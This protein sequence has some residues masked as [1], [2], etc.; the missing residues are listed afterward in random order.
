MVGKRFIEVQ[1]PGA[2]LIG[3]EVGPVGRAG[4]LGL[5]VGLAGEAGPVGLEAGSVRRR[6]Y[7][8]PIRPSPWLRHVLTQAL[9]PAQGSPHFLEIGGSSCPPLKRAFCAPAAHLLQLL[10]C[11]HLPIAGHSS[12]GGPS[13]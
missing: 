12:R 10:R 8:W 13:Y 5:E 4:P 1:K 3:L 6:G 2:G 7:A 9:W 11:L